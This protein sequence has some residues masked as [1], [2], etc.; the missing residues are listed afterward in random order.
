MKKVGRNVMSNSRLLSSITLAIVFLACVVSVVAQSQSSRRRWGPPVNFPPDEN[1]QYFPPVVFGSNRAL[2]ARALAWY[3]RSMKELPLSDSVSKEHPQVYRL[4]V[5]PA[6]G[7]PVVVRLSINQGGV[8]ELISKMGESEL[9]PGVTVLNRTTE[10]P[11]ADVGKFLQL[12]DMAHFWT[13]STEEPPSIPYAKVLGGTNWVLEGAEG[14][15][16]HLVMRVAPKPGPYAELTSFFLTE[17]AKLDLSSA[18]T[19]VGLSRLL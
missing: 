1:P 18:P 15:Q 10:V 7:P 19:G 14:R 2:P 16:Y 6:S 13:M 8:G 17:L 12:V 9:D 5:L 4:M 11:Q 3:L